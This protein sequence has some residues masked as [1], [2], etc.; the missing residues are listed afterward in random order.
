MKLFSIFSILILF[1]SGAYAGPFGFDLEKSPS[2]YSF[3]DAKDEFNYSCTTAPKTHPDME[4]YVIKYVEGVGVCLVR[5]IGNDISDNPAGTST[6]SQSERLTGQL[7]QK[8]GKNT[9]ILDFLM[10]GSIWDESEDWM[11]GLMKNERYYFVSWDLKVAPV[12]GVSGVYLAAKALSQST[13]YIVVEFL[14]PVSDECDK[15]IDNSAA[16]AF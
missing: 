1:S 8:Y 12:D 14:T 15:V 6:K 16:D 9:E 3:C 5:G 11:M 13:G 10:D 2:E 4:S 7:S